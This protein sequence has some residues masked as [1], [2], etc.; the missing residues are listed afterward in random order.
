M[1]EHTNA[2]L[3]LIRAAKDYLDGGET[4]ASMPVQIEARAALDDWFYDR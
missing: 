1:T 3:R 4:L 2:I